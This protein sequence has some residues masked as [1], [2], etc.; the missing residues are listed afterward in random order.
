M[1]KIFKLFIILSVCLFLTLM[2]LNPQKYLASSLNGIKLWAIVVLPSL[3]PF[4]FFTAL[5]SKLG[6]TDFLSRIFQKPCSKLFRSS[7]C[8]SY[9]FVMS[10]LSG[11]P[12]G[13]KIVADLK[14]LNLIDK[15]QAT[16]LSCLCSTSGPLFIVGS[17]GIGMFSSVT[18]GFILLISH[19]LSAF[20]CGLLFRFY[21]KNN[22]HSTFISLNNHSN[23][24]LYD[25]AYSSVISVLIV[26]GY[27]CV[28]NV[29]VTATISLNLLKPLI[30]LCK[31]FI[32]QQLSSAFFYGI[33]ECTNGCKM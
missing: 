14:T 5:L 11:Y 21:G 8:A 24:I 25:C 10:L 29:V 30:F 16:R 13:A 3:L 9:A 26:G 2:I 18:V 19:L 23:N 7:G 6:L 27:L 32:N 20:S 22:S 17:V 4:F 12:V 1:K 28:F 33:I 15:D 31:P